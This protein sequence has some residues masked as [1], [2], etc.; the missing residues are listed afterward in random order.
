MTLR[1]SLTRPRGRCEFLGSSES[2]GRDVEDVA[3]RLDVTAS[4]A[5]G[6]TR[7]HQ[8]TPADTRWHASGDESHIA[9]TVPRI[10]TRSSPVEDENVAVERDEVDVV[11]GI[12]KASEYPANRSIKS[13]LRMLPVDTSSSRRGAP[14]ADVHRR[15]HGPS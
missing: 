7:E 13:S 10:R 11:E 1:S 6:D 8:W 5:A 9:A 14:T 2:V 15:S 12:G 4:G 3:G